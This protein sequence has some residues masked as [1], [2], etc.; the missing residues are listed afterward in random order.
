VICCPIL[1]QR[2]GA[3]A[4][5]DRAARDFSN[6][7]AAAAWAIEVANIL[8]WARKLRFIVINVLTNFVEGPEG[9]GQRGPYSIQIPVKLLKDEKVV[10]G[11]GF[12]FSLFL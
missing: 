8:R 3:V 9:I 12:L 6:V 5:H 11:F 10:F 7:L 1:W 2:I 4:S